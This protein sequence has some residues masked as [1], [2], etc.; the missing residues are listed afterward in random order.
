MTAQDELP[1]IL[2]MTEQQ[3]DRFYPVWAMWIA[4]DKKHLLSEYMAEPDEPW[5]VVLEIDKMFNIIKNMK[6]QNG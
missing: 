4:D 2:E 5:A 3:F 6:R 1:D